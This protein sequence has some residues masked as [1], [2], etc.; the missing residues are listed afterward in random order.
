VGID[1][2][3]FAL[4][5]FGDEDP[6]E[7]GRDALY[8][9]LRG[10]SCA[11]F[12]AYTASIGANIGNDALFARLA[13]LT[14]RPIISLSVP[15]KGYPSVVIDSGPGFSELCRHLINDHAYRDIVF[16]S[17]R[18]D[19]YDAASRL[20]ILR[21]AMAEAGATLEED[22]IW[23]GDFSAQSGVDAV[24]HFIVDRG[25]RPQ[26]VICAND[27]SAIGAWE[28]SKRLG[29]LL[30]WD[31]AI[32]GFDNIEIG[33][34]IEIPFTTVKQPFYQQGYVAAR[35]LHEAILGRDLPEVTTIPSTLVLRESCGCGQRTADGV[36][37]GEGAQR[38][39]LE[40]HARRLTRRSSASWTTSREIP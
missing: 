8:E 21:E 7:K 18:K 11:G 17:G 14:E 12:I 1:V 13:G 6:T 16:V 35:L 39:F 26:A 2:L 20:E 15:Q 27:Y 30:P 9:I 24:R 4:G 33:R 3:T 22:R 19:N 25:L 28:E 38:P 29:L 40:L 23:Y 31:L 34:H 37:P 5:R 36:A 10:P 32:T